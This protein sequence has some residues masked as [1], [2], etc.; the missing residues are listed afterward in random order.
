MTKARPR[1]ALRNRSEHLLW[2]IILL[3]FGLRLYRLGASNVWWDEGLAIWAVRQSWLQATLWTAQDVHP[4]LYFWHLWTWVRLAG[5]SEF[6][7]RF[8]SALWGTLTVAV[9]YALAARLGGRRAGLLCA[10]FLAVMRFHIWWSQEMRMYVLA[11]LAATL[12][13]YC[14]V[15]WLAGQPA[16]ADPDAAWSRATFWL[17]GYILSA[18]AGMYTIYMAGLAPLVANIYALTYV[19][20]W[21]RHRRWRTLLTW[22]AAQVWA[23]L[24]LAPW[25]W[26]ALPRM[27]SWSVAQPFNP[28][29][30]A[31]LYSTLL[32]IGVSTD[33]E[34]LWP[35]ALPFAAV[36]VSGLLT[37]WW[38]TRQR[39]AGMAGGRAALLLVG[40]VAS[41]PLVVYILTRPRAFFYTPRVEARYMVLF[42]PAFAVLVA[43]S[44]VRLWRRR[45]ILGAVSLALCLGLQLAFLPGYYVGRYLRDDLQTLC[46]VLG[47]YL[48]PGDAV[49]L[50]SGSRYPLFGYHYERIVPESRRALLVPVPRHGEFTADNVTAEMAA[51]IHGRERFW[52]A[53]VEASIQDP[54]GLSLPWLDG[55]YARL[56]EYH[57]GHN[58][59]I[60]YGSPGE[61]PPVAQTDAM[62][63]RPLAW[64]RSGLTVW[65]Y[66]LPASEAAPGDVIHQGIYYSSDQPWR[67]EIAWRQG[68]MRLQGR[69]L[70]WQATGQERERIAL[71]WPVRPWYGG[72]VTSFVLRFTSDETSC[73]LHLPGPAIRGAP[74]PPLEHQVTVPQSADFDGIRLVGYD[75]HRAVHNGVCE[76]RPGEALKLDLFWRATA[77]PARDY[78]VFTHLVGAAHN[79]R[80]N[81]PVWAQHDGPPVDGTYPTSTW[82]VGQLLR[83]RHILVLDA[84]APPGLYEL[85]VGLYAPDTGARLRRLDAQADRAV[86][87]HVRVK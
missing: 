27:R 9:A 22:L 61:A 81:G 58:A 12:T 60:L 45:H 8:L 78:T 7:A 77:A 82:E 51:A 14:A 71:I 10:L 41:M 3:A 6:A 67:V 64:H 16:A 13:L 43:W 63:Q 59:V 84:S 29:L 57:V 38:P 52:V 24:C 23:L 33:V 48:R 85:E 32:A 25:L 49:L 73:E 50:I 21:L 80:T 65:G 37:L 19:P 70:T 28:R 68:D 83:D 17:G 54:Q 72:G 66:D 74:Q 18:V 40:A 35:Y 11:A 79:P 20:Q 47:A 15:R 56:Y 4:P 36:C 5:E 62:P 44:I 75:L 39:E 53:A 30:L 2:P 46:R 76:A 1:V 86:L 87:L 34:R 26:L 42:A 69:T 31:T 55:R